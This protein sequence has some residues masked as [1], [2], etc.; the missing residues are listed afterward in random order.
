MVVAHW[1]SAILKCGPQIKHP[2]TESPADWL[3]WRTYHL[4]WIISIYR[5]SREHQWLS[6]YIMI[7]C[8]CVY[9][10]MYVIDY[11]YIHIYHAW[12]RN[13]LAVSSCKLFQAT[14]SSPVFQI[15]PL[16][17]EG[18]I[19]R[20]LQSTAHILQSVAGAEAS[21]IF[22]PQEAGS[23]SS[24]HGFSEAMTPWVNCKGLKIWQA[25]MCFKSGRMRV[26]KYKYGVSW[27]DISIWIAVSSKRVRCK[28]CGPRVTLNIESSMLAQLTGL[29]NRCQSQNWS[30]G[31]VSN[32]TARK[33]MTFLH[34]QNTTYINLLSIDFMK[35]DETICTNKETC[36]SLTVSDWHQN[37]M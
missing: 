32:L 30:A 13:I 19:I 18:A 22:Y 35:N 2:K 27:H 4:L 31:S 17:E 23:Q 16:L 5:Q 11:R 25:N 33:E 36:P 20:L 7:S 10:S 28:L 34:G 12:S 24:G 14:R 15:L 26:F 6:W 9:L 3:N 37:N 29:H 21:I 1:L 8:K